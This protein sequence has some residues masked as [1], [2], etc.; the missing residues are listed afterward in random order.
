MNRKKFL[1]ASSA[2]LFFKI[3]LLADKK[4]KK[5]KKNNKKKKNDDK[6]GK[7]DYHDLN[8][9]IITKKEGLNENFYLANGNKHINISSTV[10]D[11]VIEFLNQRVSL[12]AK[13]NRD[14]IIAIRDIKLA[15]NT[16]KKEANKKKK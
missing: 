8:G 12:K 16:P 13:L 14:R 6:K 11:E 7:Y 1:L 9:E 4:K 3:N 5:K 15:S 2:I 10:K